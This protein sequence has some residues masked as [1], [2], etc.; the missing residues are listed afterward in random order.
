MYDSISSPSPYGYDLSAVCLGSNHV[1]EYRRSGILPLSMGFGPPSYPA[2]ALEAGV[3][4]P[5]CSTGKSAWRAYSRLL[6]TR[7]ARKPM[8]SSSDT[9]WFLLAVDLPPNTVAMMRL[10]PRLA[11]ATRLKPAACV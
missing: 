4:Q 5:P 7:R 1:F 8:S 11:D 10:P 6:S 9:R 3:R 2:S